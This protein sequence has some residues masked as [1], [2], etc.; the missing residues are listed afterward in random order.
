[1][2]VVHLIRRGR[3]HTD[4]LAGEP[5]AQAHA[6]ARSSALGFELPRCPGR[7]AGMAIG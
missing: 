4:A 3:G 5:E 6:G 7:R 2:L 1:M